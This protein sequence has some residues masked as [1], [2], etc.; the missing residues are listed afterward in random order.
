MALVDAYT[1][2]CSQRALNQAKR[3]EQ[4][5]EISA[6]AEDM[7]RQA[8]REAETGLDEL[9]DGVG[10]LVGDALSLLGG[11]GVGAAVGTISPSADTTSAVM[12]Q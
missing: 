7:F 2:S 8:D 9:T 3:T 10:I 5:D 11:L 12:P 6:T 4:G 1:R